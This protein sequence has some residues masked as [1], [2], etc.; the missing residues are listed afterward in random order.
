MHLEKDTEI[1]TRHRLQRQRQCPTIRKTSSSSTTG[2]TETGRRCMVHRTGRQRGDCHQ[3][4][5]FR[6]LCN[7]VLGRR[8]QPSAMEPFRQQGA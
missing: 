1:W 2:T 3:H 4:D 6:R 5:S 7:R 8:K